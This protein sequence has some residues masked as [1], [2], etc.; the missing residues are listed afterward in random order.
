MLSLFSS[1]KHLLFQFWCYH[2]SIVINI[3]YHCH[4]SWI[5]MYLVSWGKITLFSYAFAHRVS[6]SPLSSWMIWP[7]NCYT[8]CSGKI[9]YVHIQTYSEVASCELLKNWKCLS[10]FTIANNQIACIINW[11]ADI[12]TFP[13]FFFQFVATF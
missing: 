5:V 10:S 9:I 6:L 7:P 3:C 12:A 13:F 11:F 8:F 4:G 2:C 1:D